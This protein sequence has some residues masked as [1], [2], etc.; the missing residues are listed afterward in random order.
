MPESSVCSNCGADL[1]VCPKCGVNLSEA[2][3]LEWTTLRVTNY[4]AEAIKKEMKYPEKNVNETLGR[5]LSGEGDVCFR[6]ITIGSEG[7]DTSRSTVDFQ[8]GDNPPRFFHFEDGVVTPIAKPP[9]L[10][11]E[12]KSRK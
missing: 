4:V 9:K 3:K 11:V 7:A 1:S 12:K 10:V 6:I 5:M 2:G 8:L